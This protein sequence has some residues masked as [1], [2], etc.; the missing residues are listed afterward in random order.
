[1]TTTAEVI[2]IGAGLSGLMAARTLMQAGKHVLV[3]DKGRSV[4]GRMATRRIGGGQADHGAQFFTV[5]DP[6]FAAHVERWLADGLAFEW[7][8]GWGNGSLDD[9]RD[10]HPRYAVRGGMNALTRHLAAGVETR[11]NVEI[12]A[13]RCDAHAWTATDTHGN[14]YSG[15]ALL[16]TPPIPQSLKLIDNGGVRLDDGERRAL[17][18]IAYEPCIAVMLQVDGET[19]LPAPGALQR[20]DAPISWIADNRSKGLSASTLITAQT[21]PDY[22]RAWYD[23]PDDA[24]LEA[25]RAEL[26]PL[27]SDD[28]L[29]THA[30]VKRWRYSRPVTVYPERCLVAAGQPIPLVFA[31][32]AFGGPRVE[33]AVLSGLAAGAALNARIG[34]LKG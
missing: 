19:R 29:I 8:R 28:A 31:G 5:R 10:G 13:V 16:L 21:H 7:S 18:Q 33:G 9:A 22:S 11:V 15:G 20:P 12:G 4:G 26:T 17:E 14:A 2:I 24:V 6:A 34:S 30:E 32:D 23:Q 1:M 27:L 3:L 25:V